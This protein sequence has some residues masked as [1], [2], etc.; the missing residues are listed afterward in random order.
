MIQWEEKMNN[1]FYEIPVDWYNE[2]NNNFMNN[3]NV[4]NDMMKI[5]NNVSDAKNGFLKG[6]MFNNLYDQYKNY[7]YGDLKPSNK[8]E[9]LLY[10]ILKNKFSMIDLGLYLDIYPD[11]KNIINRYNKYLVDEKKLCDEYE[12]KYGPLTLGENTDMNDWKWIDSPWPWEVI[13]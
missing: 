5:D 10:N 11:D 7:K 2:L 3:M 9:E 4:S 12:K 13:K 6:N 8:R 1:N